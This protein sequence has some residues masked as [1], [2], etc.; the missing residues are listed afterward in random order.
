MDISVIT[1]TQA[2]NFYRNFIKKKRK[3]D[4]HF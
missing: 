4:N 3:D 2:N 1:V